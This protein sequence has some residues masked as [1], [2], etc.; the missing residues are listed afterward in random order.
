M[1]SILIN[2]GDMNYI[3]IAIILAAILLSIVAGYFYGIN[4]QRKEDAIIYSYYQGIVK[5]I[6]MQLTLMNLIRDKEY[7]KALEYL[8]NWTDLNICQIQS[9]KLNNKY[10]LS[11]DDLIVINN[12]IKYRSTRSSHEVNKALKSCVN[13]IIL[14]K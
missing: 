13:D 14:N 2:G 1:P 10:I 12:L 3:K 7:I 6:D 4:H 8:E 11:S 5:E 9:G